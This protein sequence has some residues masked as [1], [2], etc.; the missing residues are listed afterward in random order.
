SGRRHGGSVRRM[1]PRRGV[2]ENVKPG[3]GWLRDLADW[4]RWFVHVS[5]CTAGVI[6]PTGT[7]VTYIPDDASDARGPRAVAVDVV[8]PPMPTRHEAC[9]GCGAVFE[10][11]AGMQHWFAYKQL[12]LPRRCP[13]CRAARRAR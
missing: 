9:V 1:T 4:S 2:M 11:A 3:H 12:P 7:T 6:P 5:T 8:A 10:I 13:D